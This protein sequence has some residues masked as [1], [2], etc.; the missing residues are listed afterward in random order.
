MR[1]YTPNPEIVLP[2]RNS[3]IKSIVIRLPFLMTLLL[4]G[5]S[6]QAQYEASTISF[7]DQLIAKECQVLELKM[8]LDSLLD[9]RKKYQYQKAELSVTFANGDSKA[10]EVKVRPRGRFRNMHGEIPPLK[11]KLSNSSLKGQGYMPMNE[12]KIVLPFGK[13]SRQTDWLY[14]EYLVYKLYEKLSPFS[15]RTQRVEVLLANTGKRKRPI[16]LQGFLIEDKEELAH[17][18]DLHFC[19]E[20]HLGANL[21][22]YHY[23]I[24]QLF[25]YMIGNTDWL[26]TTSHNLALF[27]NSAGGVIPVPYDFDFAGMVNTNYACPN[28][29]LPI[30]NVKQR[31]FMGNYPS[32]EELKP[33]IQHFQSKKEELLQVIQSFDALR[34]AEKQKMQQYLLSFFDLIA[35]DTEAESQFVHLM[36]CPRGN[37][38]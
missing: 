2:L 38:Y 6:V 13:G 19:E 29:I 37:H 15:F 11:I 32:L 26:P 33:A 24:V 21:S 23:Q 10:E 25:Q 30:S 1:T 31:Y 4:C 22:R 3:Q 36:E 12:L 27:R 8:N 9:N 14:K 35:N 17:R 28:D 34:K 5:L 20:S 16:R 18:S 7:L